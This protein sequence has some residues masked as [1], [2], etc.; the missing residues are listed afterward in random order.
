MRKIILLICIIINIIPGYL[1]AQNRVITGTVR[2]LQGPLPGVS[3]GE[4]NMPGNGA[5]TDAGGKFRVT[6]KGR[7][8]VLVFRFVGYVTRELNVAGEEKNIDVS[9]A[10][11]NQALGEVVVVGYGKTTRITNTGSVSTINAAEIRNVPTANVQNALTGRLPGFFSQQGSGQPGKDASDFYIRGVSSLNPA[12]NKPLIIVDDV[13]YTYDQLQ[14]INVNEIASISVLKDASTTAIYGIKGANGVLVVTTRRGK[15]GK[16]Q[17]NVRVEGGVQTPTKIP[18]F[19]D[20]YQSAT[21]INQAETN[22]GLTPEF[23][24]DDLNLFKTGQDPYGH[25][26]VNWYDAI[27]K[28][29][30]YQQNTNL[31]IS[32]G[33]NVVKYFISGGALNQSGLVR[34]FPDPRGNVN[35]NY[36]FKRYNFRSN[37]DLKANKTLDLRLDVT[38]RFSTTNSPN[39]SAASALSEVFDFSRLTPFTAPFLNPD[40]SYAYAYSRFNSGHLPTLNARLATGGYQNAKRTDYNIM[41]NAT[42][43]LNAIT[44]GLSV[45]ARVAYS[46]QE[47]Y[48]RGT[49]NYGPIPSYHY[50]PA[51][52]SYLL[53]PGGTYVF[54]NIYYSGNT[55]IYTTNVNVQLFSNYDRTFNSKHHVSGLVLLNQQS[56]TFDAYDNLDPASV[57]VPAKFQ[58]VSVS[59]NY[60]YDGKYLLDLKAAYN[61]TDR[62]AAN[63]RF[64]LFPAIG[65]GYNLSGEKFFKEA[66]PV[67]GLFKIR[68]S[69]GIVG[70]DAAPNNRYIYAQN[71][72][73][74]PGAYPFGESPINYNMFYEG[75][76]ANGNVVWEKQRE[77]NLALDLNMLKDNRLSATIEVFRNIRYDQL[78]VPNNV[79]DIIGIGLPAINVGRT[80]N[81]GFDGQIGYHSSIGNVQWGTNFVFS[82]AKNKILYESEAAP[83]YTWLARTGQPLNQPFG[84]HSLGY[85]TEQDLANVATYQNANGGSNAGNKTVAIPDNGLPLHAGDLKY[86]DLNGDGFINIFDQRAIGHPNLP[87]TNLGLN[88]QA[89]YKG[90]SVSVL[91]QGSFNYSFIITGTGIEPFIGQ[92]QPVHLESWTPENAAAAGY[93]RLTTNKSSVNSPTYYPS[94]YWL[95]NAHYVRLKTVDIGYQFP[96]RLLPFK[97]N[98]A[99]L[100]MSAYNLFTWDNYRKYQ[101]DPEISTNTAGDAYINQRVLIMGLQISL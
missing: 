65:V 58:G 73:Q 60:E 47:Q 36:N 92:F 72:I 71:Y 20:A 15:L 76:L 97:L 88:L 8:N 67:F 28:Q 86:Q 69:Y 18:K 75:N 74:N 63:H 46:S 80:R 31:D 55:N 42:Q 9:M 32:G 44:D 78:I 59:A 90:F 45:T 14:Q 33:N 29:Y 10:S 68:G 39:L 82:Y 7:S 13:E 66:F 19:L 99:R 25:P 64:G 91:L 96:T 22:D 17:I 26:N 21:L 61:G 62:F 57:G 81:Q 93:P 38:T 41:F 37:L 84:Y 70:S 1:L 89:S 77:T 35:T 50:D 53:N 12:G 95:V 100:Y 16:P 3:V 83:A 87:N 79:P 40:G 6:L 98:S 4:K 101:Q 2:D 24:Q 85:Y 51:S 27:F 30:S 43:Q 52:K 48:T 94:D 54:P 11:D 56:Q 34:S 49:G 23:T 5:V